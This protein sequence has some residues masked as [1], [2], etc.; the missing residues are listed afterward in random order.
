MTFD[1]IEKLVLDYRDIETESNVL[2]KYGKKPSKTKQEEK[3]V[4]GLS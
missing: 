2:D 3:E 4:L 1:E